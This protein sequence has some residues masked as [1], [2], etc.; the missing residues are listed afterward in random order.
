MVLYYGVAER[1]AP[2][3]IQIRD[4]SRLQSRRWY[5]HRAVPAVAFGPIVWGTTNNRGI[6]SSKHNSS[7]FYG[8]IRHGLHTVGF[9][10]VLPGFRY[11][12]GFSLV[13][14][15]LIFAKVRP[16]NDPPYDDS[17]R[18]YALRHHA[19]VGGVGRLFMTPPTLPRGHPTKKH[20]E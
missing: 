4:A 14:R 18:E 12:N 3:L 20:Q 19:R 9:G 1:C 17:T 11:G 7:W 2:R 6:G 8:S 5:H 10:C 13:W 16:A 15:T